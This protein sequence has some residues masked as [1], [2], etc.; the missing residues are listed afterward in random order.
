LHRYGIT[1][2]AEPLKRRKV[3]QG[4]KLGSLIVWYAVVMV[5]HDE[6]FKVIFVKKQ[7]FIYIL[8]IEGPLA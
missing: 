7:S 1:V 6:F 5:M 8:S 3:C 2:H 4:S